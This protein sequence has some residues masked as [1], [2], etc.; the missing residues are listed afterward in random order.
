MDDSMF[1][2]VIVIFNDSQKIQFPTSPNP[3]FPSPMDGARLTSLIGEMGF[4]HLADALR[5]N[6]SLKKIDLSW[7]DIGNAECKHLAD[8]LRVNSS[9]TEIN[10]CNNT[11]QASQRARVKQ[12]LELNKPPNAG[13]SLGAVFE[14]FAFYDIHHPVAN[15]GAKILFCFLKANVRCKRNRGFY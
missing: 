6:S 2:S 8:A 11:L 14:I 9:L 13:G 15:L 12:L 3:L 1:D 7:N 5:V 10:I 4:K